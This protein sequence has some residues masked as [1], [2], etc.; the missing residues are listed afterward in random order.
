M[1]VTIECFGFMPT[2][3]RGN[4]IPAGGSLV[5]ALAPLTAA[6]TSEACPAGTTFVRVATDTAVQMDGWSGST[7]LLPAGT[8]EYFPA[9]AG[10]T[11]TFTLAGSGSGGAIAQDLRSSAVRSVV[12]SSA[13]SSTLLEANP[14]R[15][16]AGILNTDAAILHVNIGADADD[17]A[18]TADIPIAALGGWFEIPGGITNRIAGIWAADGSGQA[19]IYEAS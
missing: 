18:T 13:V 10:Q 17:A 4:V 15:K 8:R 14:N 6:G 1:L 7:G 11:F 16:W 2:D 9:V 3:N 12:V 19:T 5:G